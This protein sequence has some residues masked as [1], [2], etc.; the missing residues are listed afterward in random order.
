MRKWLLEE[1]E[2]IPCDCCSTREVAREFIRADGMRVVECAACGLA[3]LNPRPR[4][5]FISI[6]YEKDYFTGASAE[7]G[8]GGLNLNLDLASSEMSEK[9]SLPWAIEILNKKINGFN[10]KRVL[11]IGCATGDLLKQIINEGADAKGLEI[12]DFAANIARKRGLDV[13]TGTIEHYVSNNH[14]KFDVVIA[15][16]VIEHVLSPMRFIKSCTK[17]IKPGGFLVLSTPNYF[18]SRRFHNEWFGFKS[19]FEHIYFLNL[20]TIRAVA[21]K[22]NL[23]VDYW[24]TSSFPGGDISSLSYFKRQIFK[25]HYLKFLLKEINIKKT[26]RIFF[27]KSYYKYGLGHTLCTVL[28]LN[29]LIH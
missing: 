17:I 15:L 12:S 23:Y 6:F 9:R 21:K 1:L 16:E 8:E 28:K 26:A 14:D 18:C 11:E 20:K 29:N 22:N 3:Y 5:E 10:G 27:N 2:E 24:E 13:T 25:L 7:R 4:P 19:S